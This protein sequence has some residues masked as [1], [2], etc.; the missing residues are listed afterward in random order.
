[1]MEAVSISKTSVNLYETT[2][3]NVPENSHLHTRHCENLKTHTV[4]TSFIVWSLHQIWSRWSNKI[5]MKWSV[6]VAGTEKIRNVCEI[7]VGKPKGKRPLDGPK[8]RRGLILKWNLNKLG[9]MMWTGFIWFRIE[10]SGGLMWT[11]WS[12]FR[13][14]RRWWICWQAERLPT[15]EKLIS[16]EL[17]LLSSFFLGGGGRWHTVAH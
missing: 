14:H 2:R 10:T 15:Q 5:W 7:F 3:R 17:V 9:A 4:M 12:G 13:F 6:Y 1:M 11:R 16:M 8:C